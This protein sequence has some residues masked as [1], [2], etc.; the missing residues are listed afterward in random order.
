MKSMSGDCLL[1]RRSPGS[2]PSAP[3]KS[4][5]KAIGWS[6]CLWLSY[7]KSN[8]NVLVMQSAE[9]WLREDPADTL[10]FARNRRVLVQRQ[11]RAA[12]V[13]VCH[14]RSQQVPKVT[15]AKDND[16]VEHFSPDRAN[17]PFS[18]GVLPWRSRC[19]WSVA[20]AHCAKPPDECLAIGAIAITHDIVRRSLPAASPRQLSSK[21]FSCRFAVTPSHMIRHRRRRRDQEAI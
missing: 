2:I 5:R 8:P 11:M 10:N 1:V 4:G 15:L 9:M 6:G 14:V 12:L 19:R 18:I 16:M 17:Q 13:V 20:N 3:T 7:R 21:P